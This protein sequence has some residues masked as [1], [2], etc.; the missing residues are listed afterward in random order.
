[1]NEKVGTDRS[2]K[3]LQLPTPSAACSGHGGSWMHMQYIDDDHD[4]R[5]KLTKKWSTEYYD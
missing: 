1:M 4:S 3:Q 2:E 5:C